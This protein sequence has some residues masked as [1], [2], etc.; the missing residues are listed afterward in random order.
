MK[1]ID[2]DLCEDAVKMAL[3]M[4]AQEAE[5]YATSEETIKTDVRY[6][7]IAN[8]TAHTK[9]AIGLRVFVNKGLGFASTNNVRYL[10]EACENAVRLARAAPRDEFS[11]LPQPK[12][13]GAVKV[14]DVPLS[15]EDC[16]SYTDDLIRSARGDKRVSI[17]MGGFSSCIQET[18]VANS[19]GINASEKRSDFEYWA[20][21]MCKDGDEV[22]DEVFR[23][24]GTHFVHEIDTGK[25]G[26]AV[27]NAVLG[28]RGAKKT[29]GVQG[30]IILAPEA[31]SEYLLR[32]L[33]ESINADNVQKGVS[34]LKL[35]DMFS[36]HL[37]IVDDGSLPGGFSTSS[38]DRE[39]VPHKP[40]TII[41]RGELKSYLHNTYTANKAGTSSTGHAYGGPTSASSIAPTNFVI[42][43]GDKRLK[44]IISEVDKGVIAEYFTGSVDMASGDFSGALKA[45]HLIDRGEITIPVKE[46]MIAGNFFDL[47]KNI[48]GISRES[49]DL[50][51]YKIP[52]IKTGGV[53]IT[54]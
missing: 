14:F 38:F 30:E 7:V 16:V 3:K 42:K 1:K 45:G 29:E 11:I 31:L 51:G 12:K 54:S 17:G 15:I 26:R 27:G 37:T 33:T 20:L 49:R 34:K 44:T 53:S 50:G 4:G 23:W 6:N 24:G 40:L 5:A 22:T 25:V 41:D 21:G 28:L 18:Y 10:E 13:G 32:V 9:G 35:K 43:P 48:S 47:L 8:V 39:G 2:L 46:V 19:N 36:N 52:Y